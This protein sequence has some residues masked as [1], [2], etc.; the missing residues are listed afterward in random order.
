MSDSVCPSGSGSGS[1]LGL[2]LGSGSDS[3]LNIL[4]LSSINDCS[5]LTASSCSLLTSSSGVGCA[6]T[7]SPGALSSWSNFSSVL[8]CLSGWSS[9]L[10]AAIAA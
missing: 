2:G 9:L 10:F 5:S 1:D 8:S 3:D 4:G 7:I 6:Q